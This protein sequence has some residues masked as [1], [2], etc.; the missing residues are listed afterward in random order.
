MH[1]ESSSDTSFPR[2]DDGGWGGGGRLPQSEVSLVRPPRP[3][4]PHVTADRTQLPFVLG[5][6]MYVRTVRRS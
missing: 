6:P 1:D 2:G 4:A 5:P 3:V